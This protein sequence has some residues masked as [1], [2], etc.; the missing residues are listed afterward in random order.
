MVGDD[1]QH[2]A[3]LARLADEFADRYRRGERPPL[4]EYIDRYPDLADDIRELFP[5]MVEIELAKEDRDQGDR[6]APAAPPLEQLGDFRILREVGRGGMGVVYEAEQLSLGRHVALKVLP[7]KALLDAKQKRR[8]EREARAAGRLHHTNIVPVFGVGEHDGLPYYVM[9]FIS[10]LGLDEVIEEL[11]RLQRPGGPEAGAPPQPTGP[12]PSRTGLARSMM[13]G[14]FEPPGRADD[15]EPA[16]G[17]GPGHTVSRPPTGLTRRPTPISATDLQP[18]SS[19]ASA[20]SVVLPGRTGSHA[21]GTKKSTYW[22]SVS[23]IGVQVAEALEYA[24]KQGVL[25]RDVKPSNL[26]LDTRGTVWVTDFGVAKVEDQP[27]LTRAGDIVGTLHYLAP[28]AFEGKTDARSD[29]YSLGL[30]LYELLALRPAFAE[31]DRHRLIKQV[32]TA[33]PPRLDRLNP[34][35]PRDLVTIVHKGIDRDPAHRYQTADELAADLQH[36]ADDQ[37]IRARRASPAERLVR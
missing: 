24:H 32:T 19:P 33:E 27:N 35:I 4:H 14:Q 16:L 15:A 31:K 21:S 9:Q 3:L 12:K 17:T 37:P 28:E 26:L 1:S 8:F 7:Q 10:G 25:H 6:P 13:T 34:A 18:I 30:T 22:Q 20:S 5:A 36:F 29:V 23:R 11:K 2:Y